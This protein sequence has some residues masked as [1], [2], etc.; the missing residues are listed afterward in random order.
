LVVVSDETNWKRVLWE[1]DAS[2]DSG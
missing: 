1:G 2:V